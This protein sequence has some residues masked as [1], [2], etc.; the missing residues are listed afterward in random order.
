MF[1]PLA[2]KPDVFT[3]QP[4]LPL[5][6]AFAHADADITASAIQICISKC[7]MLVLKSVVRFLDCIG[8]QNFASA[9][10]L[11]V[12]VKPLCNLTLEFNLH[13]L[14]VDGNPNRLFDKHLDPPLLPA[15][16]GN[17][18]GFNLFT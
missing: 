13:G 11:C 17:V 6:A 16:H 14:N 7:R 3:L 4:I 15:M 10:H 5:T 18:W 8:H 12:T 2:C 1:P 9:S